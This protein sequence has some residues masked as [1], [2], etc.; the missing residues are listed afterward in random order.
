MRLSLVVETGDSVRDV[1]FESVG[2]SEGT[3]GEIMLLEVAPAAL[4]VI[5]LRGV[6]RQPLD[7]EPG[8]LGEGAG[9]QLAAVDW[10]VVENRDQRPGLFGGAVCGAKLVEQGDKVGRALG[11]AGVHEQVPA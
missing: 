1:A 9:C 7:G 10:P 3:I 8:A 5:Q 11:G 2:I 4:D 6:F